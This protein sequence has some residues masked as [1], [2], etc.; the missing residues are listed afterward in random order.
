MLAF[1]EKPP[2]EHFITL[3][4]KEKQNLKVNN[5]YKIQYKFIWTE[6]IINLLFS[7]N[8]KS[9]VSKNQIRNLFNQI[10]IND[11]KNYFKSF[12]KIY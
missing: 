6:K 3:L 2:Y 9:K 11:L 7:E 8:K 5:D 4:E 1:D 12:K 10:K